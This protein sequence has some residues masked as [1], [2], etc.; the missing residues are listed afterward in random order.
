MPNLRGL[1][2]FIYVLGLSS[3]SPVTVGPGVPLSLSPLLT[4]ASPQ[5]ADSAPVQQLR[6][7][8]SSSGTN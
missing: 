7:L 4:V 2:R 1:W 3:E 6:A 8:I 5:H